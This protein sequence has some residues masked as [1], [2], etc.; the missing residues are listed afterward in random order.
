MAYD[1]A[2]L[3]LLRMNIGVELALSMING[4]MNTIVLKWKEFLF[5]VQ[6]GREGE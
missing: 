1:S 5:L 2:L 4:A 3:A 6:V